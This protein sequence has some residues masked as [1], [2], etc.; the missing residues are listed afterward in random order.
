VLN[1]LYGTYGLRN[2]M[3]NR[4]YIEHEATHLAYTWAQVSQ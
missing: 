1:L 2:W 3:K 4:T